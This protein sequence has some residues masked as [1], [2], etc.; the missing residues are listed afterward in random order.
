MAESRGYVKLPTDIPNEGKWV[1]GVFRT[2]VGQ[3]QPEFYQGVSSV[4]YVVASDDVPVPVDSLAQTIA[5]DGNNRI[6]TITVS[7]L[8]GT[9]R[10]TY[11]YTGANLT[12]ISNW[13]RQ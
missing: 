8:G 3:T 1:G 5:Y 6:S 12:G 4:Q 2:K 9:Y 7:Y 11:T 13:V 10:Q